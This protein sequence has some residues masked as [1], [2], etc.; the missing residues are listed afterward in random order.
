MPI[1]QDTRKTDKIK[2]VIKGG[3]IIFYTTYLAGDAEKIA[4]NHTEGKNDFIYPL[5]LLIKDWNFT[6][7][8]GKKLEINKENI[9]KLNI[10]DIVALQK[11]IDLKDFLATSGQEE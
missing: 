11:K 4:L 1:L 2:S 10:K 9:G 8:D 6:G 3:E 7:E 5:S